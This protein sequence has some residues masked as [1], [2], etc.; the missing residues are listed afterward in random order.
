LI[1]ILVYLPGAKMS[2]LSI[3]F[4]L[5]AIFLSFSCL[6]VELDLQQKN[7]DEIKPIIE[8]VKSIVKNN[9]IDLPPF[10]GITGSSG[11]GKSYF[12]K[13][14]AKLLKKEGINVAILHFDDFLNPDHFD[15]DHSH[16]H[17]EHTVAHSIIQ[18]IK[19]GQ[20]NIRK[21]AWNR[22]ELRP[23]AK[24]EEN[25]C[26]DGISLILFEGEFVLCDDDPYNFRCYCE[27]GIFIDAQDDDILQWN[28]ERD[29]QKQEKTK[30]EFIVN[31]KPKLQRY[32]NC[33]ES[34]KNNA[35]YLL[36]KDVNH[37]YT[38]VKK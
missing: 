18:K 24:T 12:A 19:S 38:L 9:N 25:Y 11:V 23:P 17:L 14:L 30:E 35:Q 28:W 2:A 8:H 31:H 36:L 27:F 33:I 7:I 22:R 32:R 1:G 10:I 34:C 21:P 37:C 16:P 6:G 29:R 15:K 26:I 5:Y 4:I 13:K 3:K 20:K